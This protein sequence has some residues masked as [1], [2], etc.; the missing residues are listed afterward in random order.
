MMN[1]A[2]ITMLY[3]RLLGEQSE[4]RPDAW[5]QEKNNEEEKW[6]Q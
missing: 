2:V 5:L 1:H 4:K 3:A 6:K